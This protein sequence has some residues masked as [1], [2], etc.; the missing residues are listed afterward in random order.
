[1]TSEVLGS[2][3]KDNYDLT[4]L[5]I[6]LW[7]VPE[8][9]IKTILTACSAEDIDCKVI[10]LVRDP[11]A[12]ITSSKN[13]GFFGETPGLPA[14]ALRGT[15]LYSYEK[16]RQTEENLEL[17]R[18][19]PDS[20]RDRVKLL[21]YEDLAIEPLKA[22]A[23]IFKFAGLP[24][25]ERVR[26]WLNQTTHLSRRACN[27]RF[28][29]GLITCTKD[30]GWE[31]VNRWRRKVHPHDI[32]IIEHYCRRVMGLMGYK[33]VDMSYDL[34]TNTKVPLFTK[35]YEAKGWFLH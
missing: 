12:M 13:I 4:V 22:L 2:A 33:T 15:R 3:C 7:R 19:L 25:L 27:R 1:M 24:V 26:K 9:S 16:C 32:D 14:N 23:D 30:N 35:D 11:R 29:G 8:N 28:D 5:K 17:V 31:G 18:K 6:L 34:L 20:L 10:F 21:R